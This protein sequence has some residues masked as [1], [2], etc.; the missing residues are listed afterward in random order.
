MCTIRSIAATLSI[1]AQR[2]KYLFNVKPKLVQPHI[3]LCLRRTKHLQETKNKSGM[4]VGVGVLGAKARAA[5]SLQVL[6]YVKGLS[7]VHDLNAIVQFTL[8]IVQVTN[9]HVRK[10]EDVLFPVAP[11]PENHAIHLEHR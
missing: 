8:A 11:L 5:S 3:L 4:G 6:T 1:A 10:G 7:L 9:R 2:L